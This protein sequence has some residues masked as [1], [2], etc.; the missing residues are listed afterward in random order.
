MIAL[1]FCQT[2]FEK[3]VGILANYRQSNSRQ[4]DKLPLL[5]MAAFC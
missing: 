5:I 1:A 4:F 3:N 2:D